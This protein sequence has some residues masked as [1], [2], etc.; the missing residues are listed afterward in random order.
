MRF[1]K[2]NFLLASV[3]N[4]RRPHNGRKIR[5]S[6]VPKEVRRL[7]FSLVSEFADVFPDMWCCCPEEFIT[8]S[9]K[10]GKFTETK[11][12]VSS[13]IEKYWHDY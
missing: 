13:Y 4:P 3:I 5:I 9:I 12:I 8:F 1:E 7:C 11:K 6:F 2:S 10:K